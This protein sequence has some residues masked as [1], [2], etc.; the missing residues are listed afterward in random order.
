MVCLHA[1][2]TVGAVGEEPRSLRMG[3]RGNLVVFAV[4]CCM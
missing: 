4:D 2:E 1:Y 3:A